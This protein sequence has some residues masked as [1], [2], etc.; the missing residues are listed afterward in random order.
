M[1]GIE[2]KFNSHEMCISRSLNHRKVLE[3]KLECEDDY[4]DDEGVE[5]LDQL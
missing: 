3:E 5:Y 2:A 1:G 4:S